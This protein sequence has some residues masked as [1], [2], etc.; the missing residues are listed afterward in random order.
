VKIPLDQAITLDV[1]LRPIRPV[2]A[3]PISTIVPEPSPAPARTPIFVVPGCYVG[4]V[5][6]Q[7]IT[8][9]AGCDARNAVI[10]PSR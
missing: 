4:N 2:S 5:P 6:P 3:A 8:L 1:E 10:F 7:Q 9:P